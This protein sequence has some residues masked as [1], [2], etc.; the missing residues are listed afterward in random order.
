MRGRRRKRRGKCRRKGGKGR[1]RKKNSEQT[2][3][4][5]EKEFLQNHIRNC[6]LKISSRYDVAHI[7]RD[8]GTTKTWFTKIK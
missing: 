5:G 7:C 4:K 6:N 2:R 3:R 8:N 1:G